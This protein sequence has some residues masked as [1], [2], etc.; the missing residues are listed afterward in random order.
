MIVDVLDFKYQ[1]LES[2]LEYIKSIWGMTTSYIDSAIQLFSEINEQST[3]SSVEALT[4]ISSIGVVSGVI[5]FLQTETYPTFTNTGYIY[6]AL[7]LI[8]TIIINRIIRFIFQSI[9]Y[10]IQDVKLTKM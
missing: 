3:K 1:N 10:K 4:L 7:L 5:S 6:F 8:G 2:N 9:K